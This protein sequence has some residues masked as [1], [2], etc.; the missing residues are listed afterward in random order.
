LTTTQ[1]R[2]KCS[3]C[4][5]P[6]TYT[7]TRD[8][9]KWYC[10]VCEKYTTPAPAT[11]TSETAETRQAIYDNLKAMSVVDSKAT[12]IDRV[13]EANL[14]AR[15]TDC[16][17]CGYKNSPIARFCVKCG[18][19]LQKPEP[20]SIVETVPQT[21]PIDVEAPARKIRQLEGEK[22]ASRPKLRKQ[23]FGRSKII[24]SSLLA[25]GAVTLISS[26]VFFS[27][28]L[29]LIGLGLTFWGALFFFIR[30]VAYVKAKLLDSTAISSLV[31]IDKILS[32]EAC[33][34]KG[35][36]LAPKY[37]GG[38]KDGMVFILANNQAAVLSM[39]EIA[40][41]NVNRTE[42]LRIQLKRV[43]D[44]MGT[45]LGIPQ[46]EES[47]EASE[48]QV[49][50][51]DAIE[52]NE[53]LFLENPQG[54]CLLSPGYGLM[55]LFEK[56]LGV[57]FSKVDLDYLQKNLPKL[58]VEDLEIVEGFSINVDLEF[59]EV[60]MVGSIYQDLCREVKKL[61][62]ICLRI[63][64]PICSAIGCVLAKVTGKAVIFEGDKLSKDGREIQARYRTIKG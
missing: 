10:Y 48:Q 8:H 16:A 19:K 35:V 32:E 60:R 58:L 31:A 33:E 49:K 3:L 21:S 42:A 57:D 27:S 7:R 11:E 40:G 28:I 63:G 47:S 9:K 18:K 39:D 13:R 23:R 45:Y 54:V 43:S 6:L 50:M 34:G 20:R 41:G 30:P 62:N 36:H 26:I 5:Q 1:E 52:K 59:V 46:Q 22:E 24:A 15:E 2:P 61:N 53:K 38:L 14:D 4:G 12:L 25:I 64:C 29:V 56:E 17:T 37:E 44:M 55:K 51:L